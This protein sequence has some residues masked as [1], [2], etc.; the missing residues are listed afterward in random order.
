MNPDYPE[1]TKLH[2][3]TS[4]RLFEQAVG[5]IRELIKNGTWS[6]GQKLPTEQSLSQEFN[7]SRASV[8]E[9]L[10]VL[11]AEGLIEVK[12]GS[13]AYVCDSRN[14]YREKGE[15]ESWL[16][17]REETL[18][19]VLQVRESIEGLA[20]SLAALEASDVEL[21]EIAAIL[22]RQKYVVL[23]Q[24][25]EEKRL[26]ELAVLDAAFH[27]KIGSSSGNDIV[28]EIISH[29]LPA[30][31]EGNKALL[32]LSHRGKLLIEEHGRIMEALLSRSP[33]TAEKTMR[34][35]IRRVRK[36]I[37]EIKLKK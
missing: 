11:E 1:Q 9:G 20:A 15:I 10:R 8:R 3:V 37:V 16:E 18:E 28:E 13:G 31:T 14:K 27:M 2:K 5:Q 26:K 29:I 30:F 22:S 6:V 33:E 25:N 21:D 35:H 32:Y 36:E 12:R 7:V 19:Q 4:V 24:G 17:Q 34:D 23:E